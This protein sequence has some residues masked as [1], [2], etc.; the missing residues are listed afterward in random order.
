MTGQMNPTNPLSLAFVMML[1]A[2][3]AGLAPR[4]VNDM[5]AAGFASVTAVAESTQAAYETGQIDDS[6]RQEIADHLQRANDLLNG[7][8]E[9]WLNG[10]SATALDRVGLALN[11]IEQAQLL[12]GVIS[13]D[14]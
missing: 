1:L 14:L 11:F 12:Q 5:V 8:R 9:A 6:K 13:D 4:N 3:C 7:A 10:D 2:S